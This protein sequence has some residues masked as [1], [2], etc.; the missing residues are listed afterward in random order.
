MENLD[1]KGRKWGIFVSAVYSFADL[2]YENVSMRDIAKNNGMKASSLYNHFESKDDLLQ[3]MFRFYSK[4]VELVAP[5]VQDMLRN[6]STL[7]PIQVMHMLSYH[8]SDEAQ[9]LMDRII[10]IAA[11]MARNDERAMALI[12]KYLFEAATNYLQ[13]CL[14]KMIEEDR[15]EP[16]DIDA[17]CVLY[18]NFSFS[19]ALRNCSDEAVTLEE[20]QSGEKMLFSLIKEK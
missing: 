12:K 7:R 4:N 5:S 20:W 19:A 15:I 1:M 14:G 13:P 6:T 9:P 11:S 16:L 3:T 18:S 8:F 17:F 2:G 10:L